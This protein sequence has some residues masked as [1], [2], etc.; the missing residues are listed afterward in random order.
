ML[1]IA[2]VNLY[3]IERSAWIQSNG[4]RKADSVESNASSPATTTFSLKKKQKKTNATTATA[5]DT[6]SVSSSMLVSQESEKSTS[7]LKKEQYC[8]I[9]ADEMLNGKVKEAV[10]EIKNTHLDEEQ[11][12]DATVSRY[13]NFWQEEQQ[14]QQVQQRENIHELFFGDKNDIRRLIEIE[15][16]RYIIVLF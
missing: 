6:S 14:Q 7:R 1:L 16:K 9:L 11:K 3:D 15:G 10:A 2:Q 4:K 13:T 8:L 5:A 12:A